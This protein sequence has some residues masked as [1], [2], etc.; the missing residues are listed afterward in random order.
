MSKFFRFTFLILTLILFYLSADVVQKYMYDILNSDTVYKYTEDLKKFKSDAFE[1]KDDEKLIKGISG[2]NVYVEEDYYIYYTFLNEEEKI[3][4]KQIYANANSANASFTPDTNVTPESLEKSVKFVYYDHPELFWLDNSFTYKYDT[5]NIVKEVTLE[6]NETIN[7]LDEAKN[8]FN[9]RV[10]EIISEASNYDNVLDQERF[11]HNKLLEMV[12]YDTN[13][14]LDQTAYS[15]IVLG[16][17]VCAG[18]AKAFQYIMT[19]LG[20]PTYYVIGF[21]ETDHAWNI[22]KLG[23]TFVNVDVTWDDQAKYKYSFYNKKDSEF[24]DNHTRKDESLLLPSC[25]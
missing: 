2:T 20:V 10:S 15:S 6:F 11:V 24:S 18:Y 19:K 17:S 4:Y 25:T 12:E 16:R 22:V 21:S 3:M 13:A 1:Y 14:K 8:N 7:Y 5:N 23:D 9:N